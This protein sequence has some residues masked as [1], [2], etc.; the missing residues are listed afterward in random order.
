VNHDYFQDSDPDSTPSTHEHSSIFEVEI[1]ALPPENL[2]KVN[3]APFFEHPF[4]EEII[5]QKTQ[6][7]KA[8]SL[9]LPPT[10][11]LDEGGPIE[12][13]AN[14]GETVV[15]MKFAENILTIPDLSSPEVL[16]GTYTDLKL[17]LN[18][19]N[20]SRTVTFTVHVLPDEGDSEVASQNEDTDEETETGAQQEAETSGNDLQASEKED[21]K[22]KPE[23]TE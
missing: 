23:A 1:I 11:D 4:P 17:I 8:W 12:V 20:D 18:D 2:P 15:F 3:S 7:F 16:E 14:L 19:G 22:A 13:T 5:I 21:E 6:S 9:K 10:I